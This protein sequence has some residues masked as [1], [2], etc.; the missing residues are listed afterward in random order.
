[1]RLNATCVYD[2]VM[3][4]KRICGKR[5]ATGGLCTK[6]EGCTDEH[7]APDK[8]VTIHRPGKKAAEPGNPGTDLLPVV[9]NLI[10]ALEAFKTAVQA[11]S[12]SKP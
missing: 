5:L 11:Q 6:P 12:G 3:A 9:Q 4:A 2:Q 7:I 8:S 10:D 1:M